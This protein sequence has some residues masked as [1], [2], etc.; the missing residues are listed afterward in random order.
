SNFGAATT[1]N[2]VSGNAALVQFDLTNIPAGTNVTKAYLRLF[3]DKVTAG[4]TL[5]VAPVT[6]TWTEGSVTFATQPTVGAV[7]ASPAVTVQ[8]S[9]IYID[10]T[11]QAQGWLASPGS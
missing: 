9:F 5:S 3:V 11:T 7:F 4:G 6:S 1:L 2:V 10:V 8:N